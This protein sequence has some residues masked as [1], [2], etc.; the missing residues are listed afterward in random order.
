MN[1][2]GNT[3]EKEKEKKMKSNHYNIWVKIAT[4]LVALLLLIQGICASAEEATVNEQEVACLS[5]EHLIVFALPL[6]DG[7]SQVDQGSK[8]GAQSQLD[9]IT[10]E[11]ETGN[12]INAEVTSYKKL[13]SVKP[14]E[15]QGLY[16]RWAEDTE[17]LLFRQEV[18]LD[19][20]NP[21]YF[22]IQDVSESAAEGEEARQKM[23]LRL[24]YFYGSNFL[25][26][27]VELSQSA[28]E[29]TEDAAALA[30]KYLPFFSLVSYKVPEDREGLPD[31][32]VTPDS[33]A[34]T[35][36]TK[37]ND[38]AVPV[39]KSLTFLTHV[40]EE[41]RIRA[42]DAS[43][44]R[45]AWMLLDPVAYRDRG[46]LVPIDSSVATINSKGVL[47][48]KSVTEVTPVMVVAYNPQ[49]GY[50]SSANVLLVPRQ[51][52]LTLNEKT[53]T[54]YVGERKP[55]FLAVSA[56]P[57]NS[58]LYS[59]AYTNVEWTV[60]KPELLTLTDSGEG[61]VLLE[62]EAAGKT[63]VRVKDVLSGKTV[64]TDVT[65]LIPVTDV[66]ITGPD[67]LAPGKKG[68]YKAVLTPEKPGNK[69]VVWSLDV[70][71][72]VATVNANG[73]VTV[74]KDT[75]SGTVFHLICQAEG[76][77]LE[78]KDIMEITVE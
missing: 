69:K 65:I 44:L 58:L 75:V 5:T 51:N 24:L 29:G 16:E 53:L 42:M 7:F 59:T 34:C 50:V 45:Y 18:L 4:V 64:R 63:A 73:V 61:I 46:E 9:W 70:E 6:M 15:A 68:T 26:F 27:S 39:G 36:S 41:K 8:A 71:D 76:T 40:A 43:M 1:G 10:W 67:T 11:D 32:L 37:A 23:V 22:F 72:T 47:Q 17:N 33:F 55:A 77:S 2:T 31:W 49:V 60:D 78:K 25:N 35:I 74:K 13:F 62:P 30:D 57:M 38:I 21:A 66:K 52:S 3:N 12:Q 20:S 28:P 56:D 14:E 48:A 19:G 54:L